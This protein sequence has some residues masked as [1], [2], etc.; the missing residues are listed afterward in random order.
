[1]RDERDTMMADVV[2]KQERLLAL[3]R[4]V[5]Q[6]LADVDA[7]KEIVVSAELRVGQAMEELDRVRAA[8]TD[9]AEKLKVGG[10]G[11]FEKIDFSSPFLLFAFSFI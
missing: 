4:H 11:G 8:A 7:L 10:G 6:L 1:M 2:H 9:E 3:Q 5:K